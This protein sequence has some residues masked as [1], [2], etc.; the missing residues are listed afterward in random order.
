[1]EQRYNI[2]L[3]SATV[4]TDSGAHPDFYFMVSFPD[5][6]RPEGA[7]EHSHFCTAAFKNN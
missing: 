4:H 3:S 1:M 7:V 5:L 6:S 2:F